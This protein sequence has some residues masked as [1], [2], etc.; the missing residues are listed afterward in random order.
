MAESIN[1]IGTMK[2]SKRGGPIE[3][4]SMT[5]LVNRTLARAYL[6]ANS[7]TTD[8]DLV[9]VPFDTETY[10]I[11]GNFSTVT[12][13]FVAPVTGYYQAN[14]KVLI[15]ISGDHIA[16][17]VSAV[18]VDDVRIS[19]GGGY[20]GALTTR[21]YSPGAAKVYA[22]V[23]QLINIRGY[24]DVDSGTPYFYGGTNYTWMD[25]HLIST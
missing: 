20:K 19:D 13:G 21:V 5:S 2:A 14:W 17:A 1:Y 11:G 9:K 12:N 24:A 4:Y 15:S 6:S 25:V 22:T 16:E 18:Y 23:G 8:E 10:D 7:N 3:Q